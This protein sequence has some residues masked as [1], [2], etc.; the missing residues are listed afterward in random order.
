MVGVLGVSNTSSAGKSLLAGAS[1]TVF[2]AST[3]AA[4]PHFSQRTY[5]SSPVG[6]GARN[7][8][9]LDPPIAPAIA[10]TML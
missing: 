9:D 5:V 10:L 7:S 1:I 2:I 4:Y 8:S 3:F 6:H